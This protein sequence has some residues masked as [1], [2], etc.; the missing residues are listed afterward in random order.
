MEIIYKGQSP[1]RPAEKAK[2][3]P[4]KPA[5]G[6]QLEQDL[7]AERTQHVAAKKLQSQLSLAKSRGEL[8]E[9]KLV[10]RQAAFIFIALRQKILSLPA[11]YSKEN[12]EHSRHK[13]I[14]QDPQGNRSQDSQRVGGF[15][16]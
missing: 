9:R 15:S 10:E 4:K 7:I 2:P 6:E 14:V 12:L 13:T 3:G 8:I 11:T 1:R 5:E 16:E